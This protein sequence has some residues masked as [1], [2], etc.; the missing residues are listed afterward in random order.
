MDTPVEDGAL[1]MQGLALLASALLTRAQ[2][3]EVFHSFR[4]N[5]AVQAHY[6]AAC[7]PPPHTFKPQPQPAVTRYMGLFLM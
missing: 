2:G 5:F 6:D 4:Y 3:P 7:S 1:V